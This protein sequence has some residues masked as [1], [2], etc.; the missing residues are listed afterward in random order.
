M[1]KTEVIYLENKFEIKHYINCPV[2]KTELKQDNCYKCK[3]KY[4]FYVRKKDRGNKG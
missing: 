4:I 3:I 1:S 2:C